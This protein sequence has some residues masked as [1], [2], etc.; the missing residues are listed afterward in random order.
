M[1]IPDGI[2]CLLIIPCYNEEGSITRLLNEIHELNAGFDTLVVDDASTDQTYHQAVTYSPVVRH[3]SNLGIGGA[4]QTGIKFAYRNG[5]D[6]CAQ[7]D[8][9]GQHPPSEYLK[10]ITVAINEH[11]DI[12]IG[13]RYAGLTSFQSTFM[14]RLG[15]SL[16]SKA[17]SI[18]HNKVRVTDPTSGMR[19]INRRAM[20]FFSCHYPA[21]YPE[22]I[23]L[24]WAFKLNMKV[25]EIPVYMRH[26]TA[27]VSSLR[28]VRKSFN[29]MLRVIGYLMISI[30][31]K[32]NFSLPN[33]NS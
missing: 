24:A 21:D 2:R 14:R 17:L 3:L 22:P 32:N 29:Y 8:G 26:R 11:L 6:Y 1:R 31:Q 33:S 20:A 13:S 27:G 15:S 28:G 18:V 25:A 5:Y 30:F 12:I 7:M 4:V 16:I 10:L 23:S 9:D 19:L